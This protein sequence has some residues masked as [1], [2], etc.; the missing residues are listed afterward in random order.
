MIKKVHHRTQGFT[1]L[2]VVIVIAII[3]ILGTITFVSFNASRNVRDLT[4][5]AQNTLSVLRLT[6]SKTLAGEDNSAWGVRLASNQITL[7]KGDTFVGSPLTTIYPLPSSMQIT[8]ISL[9]G[10]GNDVIF[11]R[12]TGE[13]DQSGT[14]LLSV[15][16]SPSNSFSVT[17]DSLGKVYQTNTF[18][19]A[20]TTRTVDAR[21]RSF[22]LG[23]S[24]K[25]PT[26]TTMT[27]T[28]AD[29]T[30]VQPITMSSFFDATKTKFDWSGTVVVGGLPQVLRIHTTTLT[31][32]NTVL[33]IDRDCRK[34]TKK[35]TIDIDG[36]IIA[37]YEADCVA[38]SIGAFGGAISEP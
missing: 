8:N 1:L 28:F 22:T 15:I 34:N 19:S 25:T 2:E 17:I 27:L 11:K 31:D 12:V 23:W 10:G 18:P 4:T 35:L 29:P 13:T 26:A 21:H 7:F 9:N 37:I 14:F 36:K 16:S 24:I 38:V 20:I 3:A 32:S 5:S 6:Q 33:S 30:V